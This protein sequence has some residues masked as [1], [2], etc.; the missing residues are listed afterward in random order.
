M[1]REEETREELRGAR[2]LVV[3]DDENVAERLVTWFTRYGASE[4]VVR[5]AVDA[6]LEELKS[7]GEDYDLIVVDVMLPETEKA[8]KEIQVYRMKLKECLKILKQEEETDLR[9]KEFRESVDKAR[10][11]RQYLLRRITFLIKKTGGI[12]MVRRWVRG[13]KRKSSPPI[14]YLT[15]LGS[16]DEIN[17]GIAAAEQ[18]NVEW[19]I[20]P[21][22]VKTLMDTA[23][24]LID[25]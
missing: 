24:E 17:H 15:A 3:E 11:N 12:E 13:S 7:K 2:I 5:Y 23:A 16:S 8:Y 4:V 14:I 9:D 20:K 18:E 25:K 6:G 10:E 21:V 19:L 1:V 22:T